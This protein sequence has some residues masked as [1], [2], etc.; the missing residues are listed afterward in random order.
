MLC[1][2]PVQQ[3]HVKRTISG[4]GIECLM[5]NIKIKIDLYINKG[6]RRAKHDTTTCTGCWEGKIEQMYIK[7]KYGNHI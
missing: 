6:L 4:Y 1:L 3:V 7:S 2:S 5:L